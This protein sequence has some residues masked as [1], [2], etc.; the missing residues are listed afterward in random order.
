MIQKK[1]KY[2]VWAALFSLFLITKLDAQVADFQYKRDISGV[3]SEWHLIN[4][5]NEVFGN[6]RPDFSDIRILG[7][8]PENDTVEA[9]YLV[10]RTADETIEKEWVS[11]KFNTAHNEK[12]HF[13][14]FEM[15]NEAIANQIRVNFAQKNFDW[16]VKVEGSQNQNEWFTILDDYRILSIQNPQTNYAFTNIF[17]PDSKYRF[18]RLC[19]N[20]NETPTLL[21]GYVSQK[22]SKAGEYR[23][24]A[25][26][27]FSNEINK[28]A[29]QTILQVELP[30]AVPVSYLKFAVANKIDFY[31]PIKIEYLADSQKTEKG[32][33][34]N[35]A[36]I[37]N[38]TL[39][40]LE[41]N[42]LKFAN[43]LCQ[44]LKITIENGDN[45]PLKM[46]SVWAKGTPEKIIARFNKKANYF[47]FY[48]NPNASTPNYDIAIFQNKI[49]VTLTEVTLGNE[50]G[51]KGKAEIVAPLF[52]NKNWLWAIMAVIIA[53][54]GWFSV[55]MLSN[56]E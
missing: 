4:L 25:I 22:M 18:F 10:E 5:P 26:K 20:S 52:Q 37:A 16:R 8:T 35:Y 36:L 34:Y 19:I 2:K 53:I 31:R 7:I 49:P 27:K 29:K 32:Y 15:P 54:L 42:E 1:N 3:S 30:N 51:I 48:G 41:K 56:K 12:G 33:F 45:E 40:S 6:I 55:K 9:P 46:D 21:K 50:V 38:G 23:S 43:T 11:M 14:T 44:K 13:F 47:L 17:F 24:Y 39:S 28:A